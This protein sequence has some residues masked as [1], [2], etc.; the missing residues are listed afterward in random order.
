[1]PGFVADQAVVVGAGVAG[2][3]A[4]CALAPFVGRVVVLERDALPAEGPRH[5]AGTPQDRHLHVLLGGGERALCELFPGFREDLAAAGAVPIRMDHDI[6]RELPGY[7]PFPAR[8][9]GWS[10]HSMTRPLVEFTVRQH[11]ARRHGNV[12]LRHHCRVRS[13]SATLDGTAVTAVACEAEDGSVERIPADLVVDASGRGGLTHDLLTSTGREL[14]EE[15]SIGVDIGY[16]TALF[17]MP[18]D[19]PPGWTSVVTYPEA[20]RDGLG[21][22]IL[23]VEGGRWMVTL[24]SM[25]GAPPPGSGDEF[26]ARAR[27]LRTPTIHDAIKGAERLGDVSR[28]VL[29]ASVWRHFERL[30]GRLPRGLIPLGDAICR[31]NPI[32]GQGMSVAAQEACLLRRLL[33]ERA[34]GDAGGD[35]LAGLAPAFLAGAAALI[36]TAWEMAVVPDMIYPQTQGQRPPDFEARVGFGRA[37]TKLMARDP[38][39][40]A[41]VARVRNLLT[42]YGTLRDPDLVRRVA[43]VMAEDQDALVAAAPS[44][45]PNANRPAPSQGPP[46]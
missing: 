10:M 4:A 8:D 23:P 6:R 34:D 22:L 2:L 16:A 46:R 15:T 3:A 35:P 43:A 1:M 7:D 12:S 24:A 32:Y 27:Q 17:A 20:P 11:A 18:D 29:P 37:L 40:N 33:A 28:F 9:L 21:G 14:P 31:F 38:A 13:I 26:L 41:L 44:G 42:P 5:R 36:E 39:V 30:D 45:T 25:H 19:A